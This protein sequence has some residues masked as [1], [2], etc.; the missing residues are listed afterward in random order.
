MP[1]EDERKGR[2]RGEMRGGRQEGEERRKTE[3]GEE[4]ERRGRGQEEEDGRKRG[5]EP[6]KGMEGRRGR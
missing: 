3:R 6:S 4:R 1:E 5:G 2:R